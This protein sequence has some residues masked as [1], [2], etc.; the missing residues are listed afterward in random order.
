MTRQTVVTLAT[1]GLGISAVV[2]A[3]A[4]IALRP[5]LDKHPTSEQTFSSSKTAGI[6]LVVELFTS[7]GCSSCP[8]ADAVLAGLEK[9]YSRQGITIIPLSEHVDYWNHLGWS[10]PFSAAKFSQRQSNYATKMN[11]ESVYT[12]QMIVDGQQEFVG[13]D[14]DRVRSA[15]AEQKTTEKAAIVLTLSQ[16]KD[17]SVSLK[18]SSS[19]ISSRDGSEP[20][21]LIIAV[22]EDNLKSSVTRGENAGHTLPHTAVVRE[23]RQVD[24][25]TANE[26]YSGD[27]KINLPSAWKRSDLHFIAF[28]QGKNT[29]RVFGAATIKLPVVNK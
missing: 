11:L 10:D 28:M 7:E 21:I 29:G 8:S 23:W 6:P 20:S 24:G 27:T 15:I 14:T 2:A 19:P 1:I 18:I 5:A 16:L 12:P 22:T 26:A 13:S 3:A 4:M 9:T 17:T 25:I